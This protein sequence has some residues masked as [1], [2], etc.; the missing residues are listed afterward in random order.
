MHTNSHF[1]SCFC[2]QQNCMDIKSYAEDSLSH[3]HAHE[4]TLITM[5]VLILIYAWWIYG[6]YFIFCSRF[7]TH[8]GERTPR[9]QSWRHFC[10]RNCF[11]RISSHTHTHADVFTQTVDYLLA[12]MSKIL[13]LWGGESERM[14]KIVAIANERQIFAAHEEDEDES[15]AVPNGNGTFNELRTHMNMACIFGYCFRLFCPEVVME[16]DEKHL[17]CVA[18]LGKSGFVVMKPVQ[19]RC[20]VCNNWR[21]K[22][23]RKHKHS[24]Q[25]RK[26]E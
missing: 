12:F 24:I 20:F 14:T 26:E 13:P 2:C 6:K 17:A 8:I 18:W 11:R 19:K 22:L 4:L 10:G 5:D 23:V 9:D 15:G 7:I 3:T 1:S 25:E 16:I 21:W